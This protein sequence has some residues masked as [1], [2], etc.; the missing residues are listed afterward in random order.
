MTRM[1]RS[2]AAGLDG[3]LEVGAGR[4]TP[5]GWGWGGMEAERCLPVI[6]Y[7]TG[8]VLLMDSE[9]RRE[10]GMYVSGLQGGSMPVFE[11]GP[12]WD[13]QVSTM[14]TPFT[15]MD[16]AIGRDTPML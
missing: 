12:L 16:L 14:L 3:G 7:P 6:S 5:W 13:T 15:G 11:C 8:M 4:R 1:R 10:A 2:V 9:G